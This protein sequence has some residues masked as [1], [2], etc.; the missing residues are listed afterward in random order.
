MAPRAALFVGFGLAIG[1]T[2]VHVPPSWG[3]LSDSLSAA[4]ADAL[5]WF[6]V[7]S[8]IVGALAFGWVGARTL[9]ST[10]S[11]PAFVL[12]HQASQSAHR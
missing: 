10:G 5:T 2:A 3:A 7:V 11:P 4:H 1:V 8:E 9:K 6:A 12:S